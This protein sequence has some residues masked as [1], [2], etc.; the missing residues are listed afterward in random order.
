MADAD[1]VLA[2]GRVWA[3]AAPT[4][5]IAVTDG[6]IVATGDDARALVGA[7]TEVVDLTGR[8]LVPGFRDGHVHV[9]EGGAESLTCDL[10]DAA[11]V[12]E[13]ERR[14]AAYAATH[15]GDGWIVGYSY[16]PE[17]LPGGVGRAAVLDAVVGDRPVALWSGDHHMVWVNSAALAVAGIDAT[18]PDPPR[19]T[20]VRDDDRVPVGTLLEAAEELLEPHL[21][22]RTRADE[23]RGFEVGL[24]RLAAAGVVF[25]QEAATPP[26]RVAAYEA[27]ADA[28]GLTA[29]VD[30]ALRVDPA[31]WRDQVETFLDA[32]RQVEAGA[33]RRGADGVPGGRLTARTVKIFVD[34]VIEGGTGAL[35]EPY[36]DAPH[37]CGIPFWDDD[38]LV[39]A[40]TAFDT[41]G[42]ELH[43]HAIG[44]AAVRSAL[45]A[46]EAVAATNG[47][48][49]RRPVTAHTHLV[50]PDDL[51]RFRALGATAN[52]EPIWAQ[53]NAVMTD[54]TEP[55]L[56]EERSRWQYPFASL[57]R[58]GARVS[59]GSDW[60]V[61]SPV[62]LEGIAV[63]LTRQTPDG[64][65]PEGWLP[66]E[67]LTLDEALTAYTAGTARQCRDEGR[68]GT[69]EVGR[70]ADLALLDADL[71]DL[72][73]AAPRDLSQVRVVATWLAGRRVDGAAAA[74]G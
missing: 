39:A 4:D 43:L 66:H 23:V 22:H 11:S 14:L 21:P 69:I 57:V 64:D 74:P 29:D 16:P 60:P 24:A 35:L 25:A 42:F 49:D 20:I 50:H 27:V 31:R 56:G 52:F 44:D 72:A 62:P 63:A 13:V 30:L 53:A 5:A 3:P 38:E 48:R 59:F 10:T 71:A 47:P 7:R 8:T 55:R 68:T 37:S 73:T 12:E 32:R 41:E 28:G 19:G 40:A 58:G 67:R 45:D 70:D 26:E 6:T 36:A 34:G 1:L 51:P 61:S 9:L 15:P 54:L 18:T 17:V 2:G 33:A 65:P 46:F